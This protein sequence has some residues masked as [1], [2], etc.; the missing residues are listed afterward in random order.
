MSKLTRKI[1]AAG[2]AGSSLILAS[3]AFSGE[4]DGTATATVIAP[5][6]VTSGDDL[7][8]GSFAANGAG[9]VTIGA[10]GSRT[11]SGDVVEVT[12]DAGGVGTFTLGG[13]PSTSYSV[14]LPS[15]S[16]TLS[17]T[18]GLNSMS[19]GS[20]TADNLTGSLDGTGA[21]SLSVGAT[22]EVADGQ[23]A[24]DYSGTFTVSVDYN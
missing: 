23:A 21:G 16:I 22:L 10:D 6:T 20:F 9:T 13:E 7:E 1:I 19:A 2:I 4:A 15:G 14:T 8:F 24:G 11:S 12:A 18:L 17:D 5:I 3:Q